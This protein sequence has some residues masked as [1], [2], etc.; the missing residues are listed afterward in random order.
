MVTDARTMDK[1]HKED[2]YKMLDGR[3][4]NRFLGL[5]EVIDPIPGHIPGA[6]SAPVTDF[7]DKDMLFRPKS[8]IK[9]P[10]KRLLSDT[11][12]ENSIYYCGS[13]VT[14]ALGVFTMVYAG[15]PM[16][17]LYPG[18]LERMD[19]TTLGRNRFKRIT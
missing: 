5:E 4:R 10:I 7:L 11:P 2:V 13:G 15:F 6:V 19:Q 14:A 3:A 8:E 12:P 1:F 9:A 17:K 16:T 18:S